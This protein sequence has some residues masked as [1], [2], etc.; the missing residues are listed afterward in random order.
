[1]LTKTKP[2]TFSLKD[3]R[4]FAKFENTLKLTFLKIIRMYQYIKIANEP[5]ILFSRE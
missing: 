4:V 5:E 1:M 2:K 3:V